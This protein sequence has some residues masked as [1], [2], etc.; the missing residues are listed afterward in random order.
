MFFPESSRNQL[1]IDYW[2]PEGARIQDVSAALCG[3][4]EHLLESDHVAH[5]TTFVGQGPPR[6][7]LSVD[8]ESAHGSYGQI[9]VNTPTLEDV[10]ALIAE[11]EP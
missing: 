8:P 4:E 7:Y 1:M 2:A 10:D 6:F 11:L 5:V 9:I 3:L